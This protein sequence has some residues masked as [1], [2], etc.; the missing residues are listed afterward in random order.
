MTYFRRTMLMPVLHL[1]PRTPRTMQ[2]NWD[3]G[4]C[5]RVARQVEE[6]K[7][8]AGREQR[9]PPVYV[10]AHLLLP[11]GPFV[12][13]PDGSCLSMAKSE[14]RGEVQG[15]AE[16]VAYADTIIK[17]LVSTLQA[18]GRPAPVILIQADEGPPR[19]S[20]PGS[21]GR[22]PPTRS[23]GSSSASSPPIPSPMATMPASGRTSR[24]STATAPSSARSSTSTCRSCPT[25]CWPSRTIST[26]TTFT[27]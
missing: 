17:D 20:A 9:D 22:T 3:N 23:F 25:G 12:F 10:F 7:A 26:S 13:A 27:T 24:R 16:Q 21:T 5:Q 4:Q 18:E 8:I 11:H 15:Y 2:L 14:A 6:I 19:S 1:L